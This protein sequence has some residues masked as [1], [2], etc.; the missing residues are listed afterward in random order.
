MGGIPTYYRT[1]TP[2]A[3]PVGEESVLGR[4]CVARDCSL[5]ARRSLWPL[6]WISHNRYASPARAELDADLHGPCRPTALVDGPEQL[7][8]ASRAALPLRRP[9][10]APPQE[11]GE[12]G[13]DAIVV[14]LA[15]A[16][17]QRQALHPIVRPTGVLRAHR[18]EA[19]RQVRERSKAPR[20]LTVGTSQAHVRH[21]GALPVARREGL[22]HAVSVGT[23]EL[24]HI[25]VTGTRE[26]SLPP[27]TIARRG[28]LDYQPRF[29]QLRHRQTDGGAGQPKFSRDLRQR[30]IWVAPQRDENLEL[31]AGPPYLGDFCNSERLARLPSEPHELVCGGWQTRSSRRP[32][33][34]PRWCHATM[35]GN[36]SN[37]DLMAVLPMARIASNPSVY[38][39]SRR[40]TSE[41]APLDGVL[42]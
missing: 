26:F 37:I 9:V 2:A 22:G 13:A 17:S 28:P 24:E 19:R 3:K 39:G 41:I 30:P 20:Q 16:R 32:C 8:L 31:A 23:E 18:G 11:A 21:A 6:A 42:L 14:P 29:S 38:A 33:A 1:A 25:L 35:L 34:P 27:A 4:W 7:V 5:P 12:L 36:R 10:G 15:S 40:C